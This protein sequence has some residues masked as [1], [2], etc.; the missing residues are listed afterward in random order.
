MHTNTCVHTCTYVRRGVQ[1]CTTCD[2]STSSTIH[3]VRRSTL[4]RFNIQTICNNFAATIIPSYPCPCSTSLLISQHSCFL[5][6]CLSLSLALAPSMLSSFSTILLNLHHHLQLRHLYRLFP[7]PCLTPYYY[8]F[9]LPILPDCVSSTARRDVARTSTPTP[10]LCKIAP[11]CGALYL[12]L[13]PWDR[14]HSK[15]PCRH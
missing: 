6:L 11:R 12:Q 15:S 2:S 13:P 9:P 14:N 5:R 7:P 8:F 3:G 1:V 10:R 4:P